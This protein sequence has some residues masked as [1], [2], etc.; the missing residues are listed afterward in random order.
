MA[1][2]GGKVV[3][4]GGDAQPQT[5][6][7]K[8]FLGDTW[9]WDG[10]AWSQVATGGPPARAYAAMAERNG[11]AVLFGGQN[12]HNV[13]LSDTW[14]WDGSTWVQK[15]VPGPSPRYWAAMA[16]FEGNV[17]LMG[18]MG[19]NNQVYN[20]TWQWD[21]TAWTQL[22]MNGPEEYQHGM[23]PVGCTVVLSGWYSYVGTG[24]AATYN[25]T[26][27]WNGTAWSLFS[28]PEPPWRQFTAMASTSAGALLFGGFDNTSPTGGARAD[29]WLWDGKAWAQLM[30][31]GP[32]ARFLTTMASY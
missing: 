6:Q 27:I 23:A 28:G 30:V 9:E 24:G 3:V 29:T 18:G 1:S 25:D 11:H 4:F 15:S 21:G 14:E 32:P 26:E 16:S 8:G 10:S 31:G 13:V 2:R 20:D 12:T 17:I 22:Q 19:S 7:T 5:Y